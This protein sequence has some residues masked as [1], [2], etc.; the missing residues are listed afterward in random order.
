MIFLQAIAWSKLATKTSFFQPE[1]KPLIS[2]PKLS[3]TGVWQVLNT[4]VRALIFR[5]SNLTSDNI[6][7]YLGQRIYQKTF[8]NWLGQY[9]FWVFFQRFCTVE[10]CG[11]TPQSLYHDPLTY[12]LW[13]CSEFNIDIFQ[14][15][16]FFYTSRNYQKTSGLKEF[17]NEILAWNG[18]K[19][20]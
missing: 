15:N 14:A 6:F 17:R 9:L 16:V 19:T 1:H 11:I 13:M 5:I 4:T 8:L 3:I 2:L 12:L 7:H 18:L 20:Q 10:K